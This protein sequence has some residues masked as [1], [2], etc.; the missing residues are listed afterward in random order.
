MARRRRLTRWLGETLD[1]G[2]NGL[3]DSGHALVYLRQWARGNQL[4]IEA[5][6]SPP[7][8]AGDAVTRFRCCWFMGSWPTGGRCTS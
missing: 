3:K 4:P 1:R 2:R 7:T 5:I 6:A 8:A